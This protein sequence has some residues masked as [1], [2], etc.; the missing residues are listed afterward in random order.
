MPFSLA[1]SLSSLSASAHRNAELGLIQLWNA[2]LLLWTVFQRIQLQTSVERLAE[3]PWKVHFIDRVRA[4]Y[5]EPLRTNEF[6]PTALS[7]WHPG[8]NGQDIMR[9]RDSIHCK[10]ILFY[11]NSNLERALDWIFSHPEFEE[12][13]DFVIEMENNA[14]ANIVS[15][16]K[17]EGPRVKDGSGSKFLP[18]GLLKGLWNI[19]FMPFPPTPVCWHL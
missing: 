15:E 1:F 8:S 16:A 11:Q 5:S 7:A 4:S 19:L 14:N 2:D 9:P 18:Q 10:N 3:C 13:S 12:D 6:R 17:P